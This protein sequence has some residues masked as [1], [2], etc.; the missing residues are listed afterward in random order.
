MIG[1]GRQKYE[2]VLRTMEIEELSTLKQFAE[3]LVREKTTEKEKR[4]DR[5]STIELKVWIL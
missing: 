3:G 5:D 1:K 4:K 2:C